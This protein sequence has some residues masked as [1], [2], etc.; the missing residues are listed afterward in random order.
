[1]YASKQDLRFFKS[2]ESS[3]H[4]SRYIRWC[5]RHGLSTALAIAEYPTLPMPRKRDTTTSEQTMELLHALDERYQDNPWL[6]MLEI[7]Q[8]MIKHHITI[9]AEHRLQYIDKCTIRKSIWPSIK[10]EMLQ[11]HGC[12]ANTAAVHPR[13]AFENELESLTFN[14]DDIAHLYQNNAIYAHWMIEKATNIQALTE[15]INNTSLDNIQKDLMLLC[16][17]IFRQRYTLYTPFPRRTAHPQIT[18]PLNKDMDIAHPRSRFSPEAIISCLSNL[19]KYENIQAST[20]VP[21]PSALMQWLLLGTSPEYSLESDL[22]MHFHRENMLQSPPDQYVYF[23]H[24][25]QHMNIRPDQN[26]DF[27]ILL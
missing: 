1:M 15:Y 21:S 4:A 16:D 19:R 17:W 13:D 24:A 9:T 18:G 3:K 27:E 14:P 2:V 7:R 11:I 22:V 6:F 10:K 25:C 26:H 12:M 20:E 23:Q 5:R 8:W